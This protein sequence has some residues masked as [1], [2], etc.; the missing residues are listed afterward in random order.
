VR[1]AISRAS[2][3][4]G[5]RALDSGIGHRLFE[6]A[7]KGKKV[8]WLGSLDQL[9]TVS[10]T[11]DMGRAIALLGEREVGD[12]RVW[13]LPADEPVT[14]RRFIDLVGEAMGRPLRPTT[15][16]A[17]MVRLAGVF[18]PM[19]HE[20]GDVMYQWTEPFVE[21]S[22]RFEGA[23]GPFRVTPNAEAIRRSVDWYGRCRLA[24]AA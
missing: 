8:P 12:G 10:F 24:R 18:V 9:H 11:E 14:G 20:V 1:V 22:S 3:Y 21:D 6:A 23:F 7:L 17:G 15:T 5:P 4:F 2:D 16:T 13:H 19:I